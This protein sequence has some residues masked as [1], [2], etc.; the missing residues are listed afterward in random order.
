M[1]ETKTDQ[2]TINDN[3]A[4]AV[5]NIGIA[6]KAK[7]PSNTIT[8]P[9]KLDDKTLGN[10]YIGEGF[11]KKIVDVFANTMTREWLF[12]GGDPDGGLLKYMERIRTKQSIN[13]T[14]KWSR[15]YGTAIIIMLID[16]GGDLSEP[17]NINGIR[18]VEGLRVVDKTQITVQSQDD[19]YTDI[20]SP[21]FGTVE[22]YTIQPAQNASISRSSNIPLQYKVH[23]T[24]VLRFDGEIAPE[25]LMI[26]ND[27]FGY[28][29]IY[30][31]Y[32]YLTNLAAAYETSSEILTEFVISV[33]SIKNLTSI[34][35]RPNGIAAVKAK[36]E[37]FDYCKSV[38]NGVILDAD[39]E[40]YSKITTSIS[41]IPELIDRFG[42]ALAAVSGIPYMILMGE[43]PSGLTATGD[44]DIR[45]WYDSVANEQHEI[46]T[47][48]IGKLVE[49]ILASSDSPVKG[50]TID[51]IELTYNPLWQLD[52][53]TT[54]DMRN[55][56]ALTDQV[57]LQNGVLL[58]E[59]VGV[60]RF[61]GDGYSYETTMDDSLRVNP[62]PVPDTD[63]DDKDSGDDNDN[64][65]KDTDTD[66][67]TDDDA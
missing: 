51:D 5:S 57:Y 40:Q 31:I 52:E 15:L 32:R 19:L 13:E 63:T 26:Q 54:I 16:D 30:P 45:S 61:G 17:V 25:N 48:Q 33:F 9:T 21:K 28:S 43:S 66:T 46:M 39:G 44:N 41:G 50:K 53:P 7:N 10:I 20:N 34:L 55:K 18:T 22:L 36:A 11:G 2:D 35:S 23:E 65:E 12:F 59:E 14:L 4:N 67:D 47:P 6:G 27:Y 64:E 3:I 42:L 24:R 56:Q 37:L 49:Y 58:P 60:S 29:V 1:T 8:A 62:D 38:I